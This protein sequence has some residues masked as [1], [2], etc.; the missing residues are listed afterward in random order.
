ML[1][2]AV[3]FEFTPGGFARIEKEII[4]AVEVS[5]SELKVNLTAEM[6]KHCC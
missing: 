6:K 5:G 3:V 4:E 2:V 1:V